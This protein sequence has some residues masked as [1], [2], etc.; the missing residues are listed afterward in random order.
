M[1]KVMK[2]LEMI[3][4]RRNNTKR[5]SNLYQQRGS[6]DRAPGAE[7]SHSNPVHD[8][9]ECCGS[10]VPA[11]NFLAPLGGNTW[12]RSAPNLCCHRLCKLF[13]SASAQSNEETPQTD[14]V[15]YSE[16]SAASLWRLMTIAPECGGSLMKAANPISPLSGIRAPLTGIVVRENHILRSQSACDVLLRILGAA[17]TQWLGRSPPTTAIPGGFTPGFSQVRIVLDDAACR[18]VFSGFSR[19]PRPSIPAPLHSRVSFYVMS[20]DDGHLRVPAGKPVTRRKMPNRKCMG[21]RDRL[22]HVQTLL[23]PARLPDMLP[24]NHVWYQF[25]SRFRRATVAG[26]WNTPL[27]NTGPLVF[28]RASMNTEAYCNILDNEMLP[29]LWRV[30]GMDTCYFQDGNTRCHA[31]RA[32]MQ[33]YADNNVR[34][35]DWPAQSPDLNPIEHLWDELDR[36]VRARQARP[37]SIAQRMEWLQE[38]WR[39]IPVD[40]L[41]TLVES[42]PDRVAAVIA[43]RGMGRSTHLRSAGA[44]KLNINVNKFKLW[45]LTE[46][47]NL[48]G[49]EGQVAGGRIENDP[50]R[51]KLKRGPKGRVILFLGSDGACIPVEATKRGEYFEKD[52]SRD[53]QWLR[54]VESVLNCSC[55]CQSVCLWTHAEMKP[56]RCSLAC[57]SLPSN[58]TLS[59]RRLYHSATPIINTQYQH[60]STPTTILLGVELLLQ[61]RWG[62]GAV[63]VRLLACH[64]DEPSSIPGGVTPGFS[65][66]GIVPDDAAGQ[67]VFFGDIPFPAALS[68]RRCSILTSLHLRRLS[69]PRF[70]G[71]RV[72]APMPPKW[73]MLSS[74][75]ALGILQQFGRTR[76]SS[77]HPRPGHSEFSHVVI[78]PDD[79]VGRWVFSGSSVPPPFHSRAVPIPTSTTLIGSRDF[80]VKRP[81]PIT[82]KCRDGWS[83]ARRT[84]RSPNLWKTAIGGIPAYWACPLYLVVQWTLCEFGIVGLKRKSRGHGRTP[85]K[86]VR[87]DSYERKYES[88]LARKLNSV[89]L[90]GSLQR[91]SHAPTSEIVVLIENGA[92]QEC[93]GARKP[94]IPEET[95]PT[96]GIIRHD[97]HLRKSTSDPA[98]DRNRFCWERQRTKKTWRWVCPAVV[99]LGVPVDLIVGSRFPLDAAGPVIMGVLIQDLGASPFKTNHTKPRGRGSYYFEQLDAFDKGG[100]VGLRGGWENPLFPIPTPENLIP[101]HILLSTQILMLQ[102]WLNHK[103]DP[104]SKRKRQLLCCAPYLGSALGLSVGATTNAC[105]CERRQCRAVP[106]INPGLIASTSVRLG[107]TA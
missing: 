39:R 85:R 8:N 82:V 90:G 25:K 49:K 72:R 47:E 22:R 79:A 73:R 57:R 24:I 103:S 16:M 10:C 93:K 40:V 7:R 69:R 87:Q 106:K 5:A 48:R 17:V 75:V 101:L 105:R 27:N 2:P 84:D 50:E 29:T 14:D 42:M 55:R 91:H 23:W 81:E 6:T 19:F 43:A 77:T 99:S 59:L 88:D 95:P 18:R 15:Y 80:G 66:V 67:R 97:F 78:V 56:S 92:A 35:L 65:H 89:R 31:S 13:A 52:A 11:N 96:S 20:G 76:A 30:Y 58:S 102:E 107:A 61:S 74:I 54:G 26:I 63:V 46:V 4:L 28:V 98:G 44:Q 100:I 83:G 37:K 62:R 9:A 53:G 71:S 51:W 86:P 36:R 60:Q 33:W 64:L 104:K 3:I 94:W 45:K 34:R 32:T 38:E 21:S 68:F 70:G 1:N 12:D 41:Q